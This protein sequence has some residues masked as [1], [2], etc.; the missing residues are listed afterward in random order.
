MKPHKVKSDTCDRHLT[1]VFSK[2]KI[3]MGTWT[4]GKFILTRKF[5]KWLKAKHRHFCYETGWNNYA[6]NEKRM[7]AEGKIQEEMD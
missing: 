1:T 2:D 7:Q 3:V 4:V 6:R 5:K